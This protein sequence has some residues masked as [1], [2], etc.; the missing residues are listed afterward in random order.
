MKSFI[1]YGKQYIDQS[2]IDAVTEVLESDWITQGPKIREFE[3][4][5]A[6]YHNCKYAVAFSSGTAALHG[7][8]YVSTKFPF[9]KKQNTIRDLNSF[10][11]WGRP[12]TKDFDQFC[13]QY[14]EF[15]TT[16]LTFAATANAGLY[17][18]GAPKFVD[19]DMSTYCIDIEQIEDMITE[20]TRVITPVSYA[21]YPVDIK[22][23]RELPKVKENKICIIHDACHAFG[24]IR[25]GH[26]IADF[27]DMTILSFHPVKHIC[28][29]EGGMVLTNNEDYYKKL[30]LFRSHGITKNKEDFKSELDG[31]WY[32]EMQELG[33]N[34]R[35]TDMQC[36]LGLSQLKKID[37]FLYKRNQI[38][39]MYEEDLKEIEW[40]KTPPGFD[41]S[42]INNIEYENLK[43]KPENLHAYHLYPILLDE[44]VNRKEFFDHMRKNGI[45][46]QVHYVPVEKLP[47]Y[48]KFVRCQKSISFY[49]REISVPI[50]YLLGGDELK[51]IFNLIKGINNKLK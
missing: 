16:P 19:I 40:I 29:G 5:V 45:G 17:C 31:D 9:G 48:E 22:T 23:I 36:A 47:V 2:D 44:K 51:I 12:S 28:T 46:V 30:L 20:D 25:E 50:Y 42:W 4:A 1:P 24:A 13:E 7:A 18:G 49:R 39:K 8:Y 15:I 43:E 26:G 37:Q 21:G 3:D 35:I 27:A 33:Y 10:L 14:W 32:Y 11:S 38:A 34:Y 6:K 41:L